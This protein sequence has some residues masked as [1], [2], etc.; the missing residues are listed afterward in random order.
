MEKGEGGGGGA[1]RVMKRE[2][3][4]RRERNGDV[5]VGTQSRG[6]WRCVKEDRDVRKE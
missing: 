3:R 5:R 2:R 4:G 6:G 1:V